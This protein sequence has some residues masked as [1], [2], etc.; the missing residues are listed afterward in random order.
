MLTVGFFYGSSGSQGF[1]G[2]QEVIREAVLEYK[3][4][5]PDAVVQFEEGLRKEDY[6]EWLMT[7][8]LAGKEPDVFLVGQAELQAL[9]EKEML[10]P[11]SKEAVEGGLYASLVDACR[12]EGELLALPVMCDPEMMAVQEDL[13]REYAGELPDRS[14]QWGD[15]HQMCR[16]CTGTGREAGETHRYGVRGYTWEMA[17]VSN[18]AE[19]FDESGKHN[20]LDSRGCVQAVNFQY[21]LSALETDTVNFDSGRL[22]FSP[23]WVSE[24]RKYSSWPHK[25]EKYNSFS[26][27]C[28][29][30]PAGPAGSNISRTEL[31]SAAVSRRSSHREEAVEFLEIL[32]GCRTVQQ[33]VLDKTWCLPA[34]EEILQEPSAGLLRGECLLFDTMLHS[35]SVIRRFD[36]YEDLVR[37]IDTEIEKAGAGTENFEISLRRISR[38]LTGN[39]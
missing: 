20:Y 5:N 28:T 7:K 35:A 19:I 23:M 38:E 27:S 30:M 25:I 14:W 39:W 37:R 1:E 10:M 9:A 34:S 21:R 15:F 33:A 26:W 13:V 17:A 32:A 12:R 4:R 36:G 18:A 29:T 24:Y 11:L 3:R 8:Y 2:V 16:Q 22:A 31:L 6:P